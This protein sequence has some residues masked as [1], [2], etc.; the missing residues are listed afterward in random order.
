MTRFRLL[1]TVLAAALLLAVVASAAPSVAA[2]DAPPANDGEASKPLPGVALAETLAT[3]TGIAITPMLGVSAV[4]AWRYWKSPQEAR[5]ALPWFCSPWLWGPGLFFTLMLV[6]KEPLLGAVPPLKKP[7][8]ALEVLE[9]K[10]SAIVAT[11]AVIPMFLQSFGAVTA[12]AVLQGGTTDLPLAVA[13]TAISIPGPLAAFGYGVAVALFMVA[14]VVIW[15]AFHAINILILLSPFG[16]LDMLLRSIKFFVLAV[17]VIATWIS[18]WLGAAFALLILLVSIPIAAWSLRLA[19]FGSVV[20]WDFLTRR[21][22]SV[23]EAGAPVAAFTA[24]GGLGVPGRAW[25]TLQLAEEELTFTYRPWMV[26]RSR[27]VRL[28]ARQTRLE[29]ALI[30]PLVRDTTSEEAPLLFRLPPRYRTHEAGLAVTLGATEVADAGAVR[31]LKAI[32]AWIREMTSS[33]LDKT[34]P[35]D[36]RRTDAEGGGPRGLLGPPAARRGRRVGLRDRRIGQQLV[37]DHREAPV[38]PTELGLRPGVDCALP[39]DGG[40]GLSRAARR[41]APARRSAGAGRGAATAFLVQLALNGLWS[42]LFFG[43]QSPGLAL[44]EILLLWCA[45]GI[46]VKR[47]AALSRPAAFLLLPYWAWVSFAAVLNGSIWWL[48]R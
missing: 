5:A 22:R 44:V 1:P 21:H 37:P 46:T 7:V 9:N 19:W 14:F 15:L 16:F 12:L 28:S 10:A 42:I 25:G 41:P 40:G 48:N 43:L 13:G 47:F 32:G 35:D 29:K 2:S 20:S 30:C 24:N 27:T 36:R 33:S 39:D 18:P 34:R 6:L 26:L 23:P 4:G 3:A 38:Q 17:L 45:I 11:P 31:G 8:D